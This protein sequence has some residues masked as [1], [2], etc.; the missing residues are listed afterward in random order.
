ML[1]IK[2]E[3]A[4]TILASMETWGVGVSSTEIS[5]SSRSRFS[6]TSAMI[7]VFVRS[8]MVISPRWLF[9]EFRS[10]MTSLALE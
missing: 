6:R 4:S 10:A 1:R 9:L 7:R 5:L 2:V 8:S 3:V